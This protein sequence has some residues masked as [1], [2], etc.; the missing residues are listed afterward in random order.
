MPGGNWSIENTL[1]DFLGFGGEGI[2]I[3]GKGPMTLSS[4]MANYWFSHKDS[5]AATANETILDPVLA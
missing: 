4:T 1:W 5:L 3:G 2:A